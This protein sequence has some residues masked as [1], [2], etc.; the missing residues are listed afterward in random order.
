MEAAKCRNKPSRNKV[1]EE[2]YIRKGQI[3]KRK[4]RGK[5]HWGGGAVDEAKEQNGNW[6]G[7]AGRRHAEMG[8]DDGQRK[9]EAR[10]MDEGTG[11]SRG[12]RTA[13]HE[14][15]TGWRTRCRTRPGM[16]SHEV[17]ESVQALRQSGRINRGGPGRS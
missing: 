6:L 10:W 3:S 11:R 9:G 4:H 14:P 1:K 7:W 15:E 5:E 12:P 8:K 2:K 13:N 17:K 16:E